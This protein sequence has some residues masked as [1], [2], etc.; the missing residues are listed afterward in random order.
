MFLMGAGPQALRGVPFAG[1]GI[2][3]LQLP[4]FLVGET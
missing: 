2:L 1:P 4:E 3:E